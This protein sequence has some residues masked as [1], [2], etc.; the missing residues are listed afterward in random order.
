MKPYMTAE[1]LAPSS[2][3][4][5]PLSRSCLCR[6]FCG[7]CPFCIARFSACPIW[8]TVPFSWL[9]CLRP[10]S[11]AVCPFS[12]AE[13]PFSAA[14]LGLGA[15]SFA[16]ISYKT[17]SC[18]V[19][20]LRCWILLRPASSVQDAAEQYSYTPLLASSNADYRLMSDKQQRMR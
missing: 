5:L 11:L 17:G 9:S 19:T 4:L 18:L 3:P 1:I 16:H 15:L 14:C 2:L 6:P 13:C 12:L 20:V 8:C 7:L 10:F